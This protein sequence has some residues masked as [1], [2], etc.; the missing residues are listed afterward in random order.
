MNP[1]PAKAA[2]VRS[3]RLL[4]VAGALV[5]V[6]VVVAAAYVDGL[7]PFERPTSGCSGGGPVVFSRAELL[8]VTCSDHAGGGPWDVYYASGIA[9]P[10]ATDV[11]RHWLYPAGC[12]AAA[13]LGPGPNDTEVMAPD[14]GSSVGGSVPFWTVYLV[15]Q[16]GV[17]REYVVVEGSS[18]VVY[19]TAGI[20]N[21][22]PPARPV[23]VYPSMVDSPNAVASAWA[24][25]GSSFVSAHQNATLSLFVTTSTVGDN[26]SGQWVVRWSTCLPGFLGGPVSSATGLAV[27]FFLSGSQGTVNGMLQAG[28]ISCAAT[29]SGSS[30]SVGLS[31]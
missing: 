18:H 10:G 7:G 11:T 4:G 2:P 27:V 8:A 30:P 15:N 28:S 19:T 22:P 26:E 24:A 3:R 12:A 5:I 13:S 23:V 29:A 17:V 6:V 1:S 14:N 16:S 31:R 20:A 9:T 25:G 21:C